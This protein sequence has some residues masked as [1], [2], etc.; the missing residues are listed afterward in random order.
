MR[1]SFSPQLREG[2]LNVELM[3]ADRLRIN[4]DLF[5]FAPLNDGDIISY[6]AVPCEWIIGPVTKTG[7]EVHL[8]LILPHGSN[9]PAAVAFPEQVHVTQTG[10][11]NVPSDE[12]VV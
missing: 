8:T 10:K 9:P 12:G 1:I 6:G 11:V 4:G 3:A 5:N 7:G 2:K